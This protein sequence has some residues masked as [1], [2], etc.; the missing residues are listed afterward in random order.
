MGAHA[1]F[2][3][4]T[5]GSLLAELKPAPESWVIA[6]TELPAA[7]RGLHQILALA[8]ADAE[9]RR[10]LIADLESALERAGIFPDPDLVRELRGRLSES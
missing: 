6:A 4:E 1:R 7:P 2:D 3:E 9:F 10:D 8:E 5:L